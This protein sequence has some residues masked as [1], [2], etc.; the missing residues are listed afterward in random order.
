MLIVRIL[1]FVLALFA[2]VAEIY[3]ISFDN[4]TN[5]A[6]FTLGGARGAPITFQHS[7]GMAANALYVGVSNNRTTG[8]APVVGGCPVPLPA[9]GTVTAISYGGRT[10]FEPLTRSDINALDTVVSANGCA[11]VEIFRLKTPPTGNNTL[12][13]TV[14]AGGDYLVIGVISFSAVDLSTS[15]TGALY[16]ATGN[17][18][19]PTV[20]VPTASN[21]IVV[22][23]IA[24]EFSGLDITINPLTN[25]NQSRRWRQNA[26]P[27]PPPPFYVG[28][29]STKPA[30]FTP[31]VVMN[32]QLNSPVNWAM[33]GILVKDITTAS[34]ASIGGQVKSKDGEPL[35][36]VLI[37]LENLQTSEK[38]QTKTDEKGFYS[39]ENLT[40]VNLYQIRA[41]N[42]FHNFSPN[43]RLIS[44]TESLEGVDF[45]AARRDRKKWFIRQ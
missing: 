45:V 17:D 12:S 24:A 18:A 32:W 16:P 43:D 40:L 35:A 38:F 30:V 1:I 9:T 11:S 2:P 29:G 37:T 3:A 20:T 10:D 42:N 7:T 28:A 13:V 25:P 22:D 34:P 8:T 23:T 5:F 14:P 39:I 44:L 41:Y 26:D 19:S 33:G 21:G 15:P 6:D 31:S 4:A 36:N 27:S